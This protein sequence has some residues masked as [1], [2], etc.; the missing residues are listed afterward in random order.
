MQAQADLRAGEVGTMD[1]ENVASAEGANPAVVDG[2]DAEEHAELPPADDSAVTDLLW[3]ASLGFAEVSGAGEENGEGGQAQASASPLSSRLADE[4]WG[5]SPAVVPT[6]VD[7]MAAL[8][9]ADEI[10]IS[11]QDDLGSFSFVAPQA[12]IAAGMQESAG[13]MFGQFGAGLAATSDF[14]IPQPMLG[15]QDASEGQGGTAIAVGATGDARIDGLLYGTQWSNFTLTYSDPDAAADFQPG[16]FIDRNGNTVSAQNEGFSRLSANQL[17]TIHFAL[18]EAIYTQ[19]LGAPGFSV[20]GFT[21]RFIDYGIAASGEGVLRYMNTSDNGT[22]LGYYP[23]NGSIYAGDGWMGSFIQTPVQGNYQWNNTI[24]EIGHTLGLKHGQETGGPGNTALPYEYDSLEF[25][26]MTYRSYV[27]A[28]LTGYQNEQWGFPQTWMMLDIA[29]LQHMYGADFG[30]NG[31]NTIYTWDPATGRSYVNGL[32]GT[33]PGGNRI[34]MTIWDGNGTDTY[35]LRNYAANLTIDLAPGGHSTFSAVQLAYLGGGNFARGNVFNALQYNGDPRSLI[36]NALGGSGDDRINGN[37]AHNLLRG[38]AG[39]D[40]IKGRDGNDTIYGDSYN[41]FVYGD[42]G[43]DRLYGGLGDDRAY[44]G[45]GNDLVYGDAGVDRLFGGANDDSLY[46]GTEGDYIYGDDGE[47]RGYGSDGNDRMYGGTGIDRFY[48]GTGNDQ[49]YGGAG[50]DYLYG[51]AG[52]DY[53]YGDDGADNLYGGDGKDGLYGGNGLDRLY[54]G[55]DED[56]LYGGADTDYLYGDADTDKLYGDDGT[57]YLYG[58]T[59]GDYL[60]GGNDTDHLYGGGG[61]DRLYGGAATDRMYG[62]DDNDYLYGD[63]GSDVMHGE[64]GNDTLYGGVNS[65]KLYGGD[66]DDRFYGGSGN[67]TMYGGAGLDYAYYSGNRADYSVVFGASSVIVTH[68]TGSDGFDTL[69]DI[70]R[71]AFADLTL[72]A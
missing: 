72:V 47:D 27:G 28:P 4:G 60:Y 6:F 41:D 45:D 69:V 10:R 56:A 58:G 25:S 23:F 48:G 62:G 3:H 63:A 12:A 55:I 21:N 61:I 46:G 24:H 15:T 13:G 54:G 33:N 42:A 40:T 65:D 26:L 71:I 57:D 49:I 22:G 39:D 67:D 7:S 8:W 64:A 51:E 38:S 50:D 9:P 43:E 1:E 14:R 29:A 70:E 11:R 66:G 32:L 31:G 35:D 59:S 17:M 16:Y 37:A 44:G 68:L 2:A 36:E 5:A 18:N 19:P 53:A 52:A 30:S 34:F 20:E